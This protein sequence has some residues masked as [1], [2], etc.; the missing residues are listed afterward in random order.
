MTDR[1]QTAVLGML[2]AAMIVALVFVGLHIYPAQC[3][4]DLAITPP[5]IDVEHVADNDSLTVWTTG[6]AHVRSMTTELSVTVADNQSRAA[7]TLTWYNAT[8]MPDLD[9]PP[10][11]TVS[12]SELPFDLDP[13]D[14]F[15]VTWRGSKYRR[16]VPAVAVRTNPC[17]I[18]TPWP[19][20]VDDRS[21]AGRGTQPPD[22]RE[23]RRGRHRATGHDEPLSPV[24]FDRTHE[25]VGIPR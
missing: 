15:V 4:T 16:T 9:A 20:S 11:L 8:T 14:E 2:L 12:E 5:S 10:N 6:D 23:D 18:T 24:R 13:R 22:A 17:C 3:S 1:T 7:T 25:E 19:T 21:M